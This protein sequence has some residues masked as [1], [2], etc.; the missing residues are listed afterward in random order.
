M[1]DIVEKIDDLILQA[2]TERSHY[3][4]ANTLKEA[5]DE[6]VRLR[7]EVE[8]LTNP[9]GKFY[10]EVVSH[11]DCVREVSS[12]GRQL[13]TVQAER[14]RLREL[15]VSGRVVIEDLMREVSSL[16]P[17]DDTVPM[18]RARTFLNRAALKVGDT[19]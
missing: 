3:Y 15:V 19:P 12:L 17:R 9:A 6:I 14:D 4:T 8:R 2:T 7:A 18:K 13:G 1:I 5:R 16:T 11:D 10:Y